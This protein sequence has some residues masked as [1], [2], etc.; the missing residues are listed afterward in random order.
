MG[1]IVLSHGLTS[2]GVILLVIP[3]SL[4]DYSVVVYGLVP[5]SLLGYS[6]AVPL[7]VPSSLLGYSLRMPGPVPGLSR[8]SSRTKGQELRQFIIIIIVVVALSGARG[9]LVTALVAPFGRP[10]ARA[11]V[12]VGMSGATHEALVGVSGAS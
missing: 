5:S 9:G 2:S 6:V 4:L 3:S 10:R 1:G 8:P 7:P 12:L 11:A